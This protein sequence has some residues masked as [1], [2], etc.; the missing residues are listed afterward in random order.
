VRSESQDPDDRLSKPAIADQNLATKADGLESSSNKEQLSKAKIYEEA[1]KL[2]VILWEWRHKVM[3]NFFTVIGGV[4]AVSGWLYKDAKAYVYLAL[5]IAGAYSLI[6]LFIH[7]RH[8]R[9]LRECHRIAESIELEA[10]DSD[11]G[12][13]Y[14]SIRNIHKLRGSLTQILTHI[15]LSSAV[16]FFIVGVVFIYRRS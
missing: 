6:S 16:V 3:T 7:R 10:Y 2:T 8:T 14:H 12:A 4:L 11:A 13:I 15:Y 5:L 9:I 1:A